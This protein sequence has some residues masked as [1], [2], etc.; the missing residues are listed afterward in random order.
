MSVRGRFK[1]RPLEFRTRTEAGGIVSSVVESRPAEVDFND[2]LYDSKQRILSRGVGEC[3]TTT[4]LMEGKDVTCLLGHSFFIFR[5]T[6]AP[7]PYFQY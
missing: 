6:G 7:T 1:G 2:S 5:L 4:V 3:P